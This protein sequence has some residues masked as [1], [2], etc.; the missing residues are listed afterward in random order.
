MCLALSCL[1]VLSFLKENGGGVDLGRG[2]GRRM[3]TGRSGRQK[4]VVGIYCMR[5]ESISIKIKYLSGLKKK[6]RSNHNIVYHSSAAS[7]F[8]WK[9]KILHCSEINEL[10]T[11]SCVLNNIMLQIKV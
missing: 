4:I 7:P 8:R 10:G 6:S 11:A 1:A 9:T 3:G 5:E 2:E